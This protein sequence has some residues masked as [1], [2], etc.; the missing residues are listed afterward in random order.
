MSHFCS[1][2]NRTLELKCDICITK[3]LLKLDTKIFTYH[4]FKVVEVFPLLPFVS[5]PLIPN[6]KVD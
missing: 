1:T 6:R 3:S 4:I 5:T 2:R